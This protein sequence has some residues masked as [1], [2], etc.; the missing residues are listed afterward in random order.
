MV[1]YIQFF[2]FG[3]IT[4]TLMAIG[5][6]KCIKNNIILL[7]IFSIL[8]TGIYILLN[9]PDVAITEAS[10][11]VLL[12]GVFIMTTISSKKINGFPMYDDSASKYQRL[13]A[14]IISIALCALLSIAFL[15]LP[16][17][18]DANN[19]I[20][21]LTALYIEKT[22]DIMNFP[23]VV[24]AI[25]ASFRGFDTLIETTVVF[26]AGIIVL[27]LLKYEDD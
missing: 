19:K 3:L 11:G 10:I 4:L 8:S 26:L 16:K 2:L 23:N 14:F 1:N 9:A 15:N 13:C 17:F 25:L 20:H 12:S 18:G 27:L 22:H 6:S 7:S 5:Y 24:S 21:E